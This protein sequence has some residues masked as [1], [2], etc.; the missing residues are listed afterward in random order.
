[1]LEDIALRVAMARSRRRSRDQEGREEVEERLA[2][3][4][5]RLRE[6]EAIAR[7]GSVGA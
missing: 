1:M 6:I 5:G 3:L 7:S 2:L 4:E